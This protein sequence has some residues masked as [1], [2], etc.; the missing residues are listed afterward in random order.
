MA[1]ITTLILAKNEEQH[2]VDCIKT[3]Q[4]TDEV[5]VID[6]YSTDRTKELAES[7]GARVIQRAMN[8]DWGQQQTFAIQHASHEWVLFLDADERISEP[9]AKE[10]REA[11][12]KNE[13]KA[14]WI[15]RENLFHHYKANHGTLR[16]DYLSSCVRLDELG[17]YKTRANIESCCPD[18][19]QYD[20]LIFS[21]IIRFNLDKIKKI[22]CCTR[23][24]LGENL[25][26]VLKDV[27]KI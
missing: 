10:I 5:L 23:E 22:A 16:P 19:T 6:D 26:A 24:M 11:V 25:Y 2:I 21:Q 3:V 13:Q 9:L 27:L 1:K 12:E 14:Y 17:Q 18:I 20:K 8:G 15:R 7:M 4:F